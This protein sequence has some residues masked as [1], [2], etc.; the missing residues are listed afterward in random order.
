MPSNKSR[1]AS[2]RGISSPTSTAY[3]AS[4]TSPERT[5]TWRRTEQQGRSSVCPDWSRRSLHADRLRD[6]L[7]EQVTHSPRDAREPW[8]RAERAQLRIEAGDG[9]RS[10]P[11]DDP[12]VGAPHSQV[13]S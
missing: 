2:N 1:T 11:L 3:S 6:P 10:V 13:E 9:A 7:E 4:T 8:R 5:A 12:A